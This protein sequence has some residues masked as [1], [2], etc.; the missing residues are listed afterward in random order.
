MAIEAVT[1]GRFN[2]TIES[3][4]LT[5]C[6]RVIGRYQQILDISMRQT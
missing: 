2:T 4:H 3:F 1:D 6:L 5:V